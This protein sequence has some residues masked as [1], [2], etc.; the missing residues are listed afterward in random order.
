MVSSTVPHSLPQLPVEAAE[1]K[2][3]LSESRPVR[4]RQR[5]ARWQETVKA[6]GTGSE[7]EAK[8]PLDI[9][10]TWGGTRI[11]DGR[12]DLFHTHERAFVMHLCVCS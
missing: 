5:A 2:G 7:W 4:A 8:P 12:G 6:C 9:S 11:W 10:E 3:K 1:L